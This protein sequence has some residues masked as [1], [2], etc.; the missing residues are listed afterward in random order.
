MMTT[1]GVIQMKK[2]NNKSNN[3]ADK[4][5][6]IRNIVMILTAAALCTAMVFTYKAQAPDNTAARIKI[7]D[8]AP[9]HRADKIR[10]LITAQINLPL[11]QSLMKTAKI[12]A[13]LPI[14]VTITT[15]RT[16]LSPTVNPLPPSR[17][18]THHSS[19][20][21]CPQTTALIP[22]A[23]QPYIFCSV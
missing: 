3:Q 15:P 9:K 2:A 18:A 17:A 16:I 19:R 4:K 8:R 20:R 6:L 22:A 21:P 1:K 10:R 14:T 11:R 12:K 23:T 7:W 5:R 13:V